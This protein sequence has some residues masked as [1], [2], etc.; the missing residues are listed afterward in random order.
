[1]IMRI[2]AAIAFLLTTAPLA[3]AQVSD[4]A[5]I[6]Y[7]ENDQVLRQELDSNADG[8]T[9]TWIFFEGGHPARQE[10]DEDFEGRVDLWLFFVG[11][12]LV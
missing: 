8:R 3:L 6:I 10:Q 5:A 1:M 9:D 2:F 7:Y 11:G 4:P 12:R